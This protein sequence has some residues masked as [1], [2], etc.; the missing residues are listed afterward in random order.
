MVL[1]EHDCFCDKR[2]AAQ[3]TGV[4]ERTLDKWA[5]TDF[6]PRWVKVGRLRRYRVGDLYSWLGAQPQFGGT[7]SKARSEAA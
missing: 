5:G 7:Q 4:S 1:R 2:L 3:I 6:G